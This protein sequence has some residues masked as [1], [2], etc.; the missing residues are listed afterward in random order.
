MAK[1]GLSLRTTIPTMPCAS[2]LSR[3]VVEGVA[4]ESVPHNPL[5]WFKM[6]APRGSVSDL[7]SSSSSDAE[8][9]ARC[10]EA[11]MPAW[12]LEQRSRGLEKPRAGRG[13][14]SGSLAEGRRFFP[15]VLENGW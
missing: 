9:L 13:L 14:C 11:A 10:R 12:G 3:G 2:P 8:E 15:E 1:R 7:E 6:T 5:R 4:S